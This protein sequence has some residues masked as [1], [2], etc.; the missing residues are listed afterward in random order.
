MLKKLFLLSLLVVFSNNLLQAHGRLIP[1]D[2]YDKLLRM[3]YKVKIVGDALVGER[4][5]VRTHSNDIVVNRPINK[6]FFKG[7]STISFGELDFVT[8]V[9]YTPTT[10][11]SIYDLQS[12]GSP[13]QI[14]QNPLY[15][16]QIHAVYMTA[17]YNDPSFTNRRC[18]YFYSSNR[19]VTWTFICEVP[20]VTRSGYVCV[21]GMSDGNI[22]VANH[23][24]A[25]G[26][27][28]RAQVFADIFPG[29]GSFVRL[30]PGDGGHVAI[31]P[32]IVATSSITNPNKFFLISSQNTP[33]DT[34]FFNVGTSL[35]APGT[36]TGWT[37]Q[38]DCDVA[39]TYAVARGDDG[40]IGVAYKNNEAHFLANSGDVYFVESTD[41]GA[42]FSTPLKIFDADFS[43]TGDS[44]GAIRGVSISYQYDKPKVVFETIWQDP[45]LGNYRPLWPSKIRF[46]STTLPGTDPD[47][48]IVIAD[49]NN[50]WYPKDSLFNGP[51]DV[52][53]PLCRP[54]IG[55]SSDNNALFSAFIV[56]TNKFM[57]MPDTA[58]FHAIYLTTSADSGATWLKPV[59]ITPN[60]PVMDWTYPSMTSIN[61]VDTNNYYVNMTIQKDTIPG[62]FVQGAVNGPSLAQLMFTRIKINKDSVV[63]GTINNFNEIP[64]AYNLQQNYPNP[65]NPTTT[66]KYAIPR[67][68]FV[69]LKV[70]DVLGKEVANL[71]NQE[72]ATGYYSVD[73][74]GSNL[75]S[76][77]YFYRIE[78]A[79]FIQTRKMLLIK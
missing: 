66:I 26:G 61:D 16:D 43:P 24:N 58:N 12:N 57:G 49:T 63:T 11:Q 14:W 73:F 74:D 15:P 23:S 78:S 77:V 22:L 59:K 13:V 79:G 39:E 27:S 67:P 50:V 28:T 4:I 29:L 47:R 70:Y 71:V 25:G 32:R 53:G 41:D 52:F 46:W 6:S 44:L 68:G 56:Q 5:D 35:T 45:A 18:K 62:S 40:R 48:S 37:P 9:G 8:S 64:N 38:I 54:V 69:S 65:F 51:N 36:Y 19:G 21:T 20:I 33:G 31:W 3:Q 34:A 42:T 55:R 30:D 75:G 60:S 7:P 2:Q 76:G 10:G 17:N 72:M 1:Q